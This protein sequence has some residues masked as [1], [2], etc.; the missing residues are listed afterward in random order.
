MKRLF[1]I[2]FVIS[3]LLYSCRFVNPIMIS[4][5]NDKPSKSEGTS[6]NGK[7]INGKRLPNKGKNFEA[8]SYLFTAFCRN[9]REKTY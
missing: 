7:L 5:E 8:C 1:K 4:M 2:L 6:N 3:I 9:G